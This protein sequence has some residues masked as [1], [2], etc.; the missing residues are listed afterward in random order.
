MSK[1]KFTPGPWFVSEDITRDRDINCHYVGDEYI[2]GFN[3]ESGAKE[4]VSCEG[5]PGCGDEERSNAHL[6]AAAPDL[7]EALSELVEEIGVELKAIVGVFG[8]S[9]E[10]TKAR[11]AL[12]KA[13]GES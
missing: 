3:I 10:I 13:R 4:I 1:E 6:I 8:E 9:R 11:A 2:A 7:Y 5:I 12:A